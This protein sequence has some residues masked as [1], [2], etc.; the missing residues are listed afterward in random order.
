MPAIHFGKQIGVVME[1]LSCLTQN[2]VVFADGFILF[3]IEDI[4]DLLASGGMI[5]S[6]TDNHDNDVCWR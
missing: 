4:Q 1:K 6:S 5:S 3:Q 2:F